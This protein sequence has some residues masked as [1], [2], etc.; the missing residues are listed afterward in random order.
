[1]STDATAHGASAAH[2]GESTGPRLFG[3]H[4]QGLSTL[5]FTEMW[6]RFSYYGM[7]A[8]LVLYMVAP[9]T[10]GG[11]GFSNELAANIY[12][13][14]TM[15]VYMTSI[16]GGFIADNLLGARLSVLIGGMIIACGHFTMAIPSIAAFYAGLT[17]IVIGTGFLKPNISTMLGSL[18]GQN[19]HRRDGG[20]SIF[21]MGINIGAALS[22]L[23][24]GFLAQ[25]KEFKNFL[26]SMHFN[27][28]TSWHWGFAA[29]GFGM[30]FGVL[31]FVL[32]R[33]KLKGVGLKPSRKVKAEEEKK[34]DVRQASEAA[35]DSLRALP[36]GSLSDAPSELSTTLPSGSSDTA[37]SDSSGGS[38]SDSA[39]GTGSDSLGSI[40][41][42]SPDNSASSTGATPFLTLEEVKR[43]GAIAI[44]FFFTMI[45]WSVYEQ[46][47]SSLNLFADR[48]TDCSILG[49]SFP[50]SWFQSLGAVFV[51]GLAPLFSILWQRLGDR[52]PSAPAKFAYGLLFLGLG[53][54]LM[55]PASIL[56]QHGKVGPMWLVFVYFFQCV[57]EMCLSP[58][59]LSTVTKLAP[60]RFLSSTMGI[61]FLA[62]SFG[63]RLAGYLGGMFN[64][65]DPSSMVMLFGGMA[66]AV[67]VC[68]LILTALTPTV[69]KLMVGVR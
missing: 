29:A 21:Y 53:T 66:A 45:F 58:V 31:Q 60:L 2:S 23:V 46:G 3:N 64:Q 47:G 20:F 25:S 44:L 68:T 9:P 43:L 4:P 7:R 14:Y 5:F 18:Y 17:L 57:G 6:E 13:T 28:I 67:F 40:A 19:D 65:N 32:Q 51:I 42:N 37:L 38:A 55:V 52:E 33:D 22:P 62:A 59:G 39:G 12:G 16:P 50:S 1:V 26:V 49:W 8:L 36:S 11:L 30:V 24:C 54:L 63:N 35:S 56:A 61:W 10:E 34:E 48:L 27:P 69:R 15:M 41:S